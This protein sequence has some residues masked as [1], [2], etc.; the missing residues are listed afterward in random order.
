MSYRSSAWRGDGGLPMEGYEHTNGGETD[1]ASHA[2]GEIVAAIHADGN[3]HAA[4]IDLKDAV[5]AIGVRLNEN[6]QALSVHLDDA[7][8]TYDARVRQ[9]AGM[10]DQLAAIQQELQGVQDYVRGLPQDI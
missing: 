4:A 7:N 10:Q 5:A 3:G 8:R 6:L 1:A 9:I 2:G